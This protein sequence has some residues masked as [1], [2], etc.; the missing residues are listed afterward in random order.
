MISLKKF[1]MKNFMIIE[2]VEFDFSDGI[3]HVISGDNGA[4]KSA[5][6]DGL[7]LILFEN[8][9]ADSYKEY[10]RYGSEHAILHLDALFNGSPIVFDIVINSSDKKSPLERKMT[11]KDVEYVNS[12]IKTFLQE[13][14]DLSVI[15]NVM[16]S[17]QKEDSNVSKLSP[18]Q[19]R[20]LFRNMFNITFEEES[21]IIQENLDTLASE[22]ESY[23]NDLSYLKNKRFTRKP[24]NEILS[25][26]KIKETKL[27]LKKS[28][29]ELSLLRGY[30]LAQELYVRLK[31]NKAQVQTLTEENIKHRKKIDDIDSDPNLS[32]KT[33]WKIKEYEEGI[34]V[35]NKELADHANKITSLK[36]DITEKVTSLK[37]E[38]EHEQDHKDGMCV[39]CRRPLDPNEIVEWESKVS[40]LENDISILRTKLSLEED[41]QNKSKEKIRN[42][43]ALL[44]NEIEAKKKFEAKIF[45]AD[46]NIKLSIYAIKV[47]DDAIKN[48]N[49]D[50]DEMEKNL[51]PI[52]DSFNSNTIQEKEFLVQKLEEILSKRDIL[53]G[54]NKILEAQNQVLATEEK[55]NLAKIDEVIK[56]IN[57]AEM[58]TNAN[59]LAM[60]I[61]TVDLVNY[62]IIKTCG[63]LENYINEFIETV[64]SDLNI[65]LIQTKKGVELF[66]TPISALSTE[67]ANWSSI[68]MASGFEQDL[69]STAFKIA[70]AKAYNL[71]VL[72]LDEIDS[73][74]TESNSY[75]LFKII[76]KVSDF[77]N[78]IIITHKPE[79]SKI[80][81][82]DQPSLVSY[83]VEKGVYT[84]E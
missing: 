25:E 65:K 15:E 68:K 71:K 53:L 67:V 39:R 45:E 76:S 22:I 21:K 58:D 66:Y 46:Q 44:S 2:S 28:R 34:Q 6:L 47:N 7:A 40:Q 13:N 59:N 24:L 36:M 54:Q 74:S 18:A 20:D 55:E 38:K 9:R 73:A 43:S 11:Y 27:I 1:S 16:F 84:Q 63:L 70:L 80:I 3:F 35:L 4:G 31:R 23:N 14:V 8:K 10:V 30:K 29:D 19:R 60:K 79:V 33:T 56:K 82:D 64:K 78:I 75:E 57:K 48:L 72:I 83:K 52:P 81:S 69:V 17:M 50:I 61:L 77:E 32:S 5:V 41:Y 62:S 12:E 49:V 51:P 26:D 42:I 37:H